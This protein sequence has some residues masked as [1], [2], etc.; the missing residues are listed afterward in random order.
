MAYL[1]LFFIVTDIQIIA[2]LSIFFLYD[3][4][5]DDDH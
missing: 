4:N 2:K 3:D 1:R 5:D